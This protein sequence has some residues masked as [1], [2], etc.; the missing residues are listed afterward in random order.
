MDDIDWL[1]STY[2]VTVES[3][4]EVRPPRI[5]L[6]ITALVS[7]VGIALAFVNP[8]LG[9]LGALIASMI[10]GFTALTDQKRR[11]ESNY[12]DFTWFLPTLRSIRLFALA[13]ACIN[14]V[15][16]AIEIARGSKW[17]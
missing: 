16:W 11:A 17:L 6:L 2:G 4:K 9:Y 14:M 1:G 15:L 5:P 10:G 8:R 3:P 13:V 12:I 7:V